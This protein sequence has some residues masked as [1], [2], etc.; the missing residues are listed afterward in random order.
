MAYKSV[1][2]NTNLK[3]KI[4]S[5]LISDTDHSLPA[6]PQDLHVSEL[7]PEGSSLVMA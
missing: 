7:L 4:I 1:H 3:T 6:E 5:P 2:W